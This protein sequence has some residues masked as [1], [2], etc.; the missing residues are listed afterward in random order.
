MNFEQ[1]EKE[2]KKGLWMLKMNKLIKSLDSKETFEDEKKKDQK[3]HRLHS[4]YIRVLYD[5]G[6][7]IGIKGTSILGKRKPQTPNSE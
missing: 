6:Q 2:L 5:D 3:D 1:D 7:S 4:D